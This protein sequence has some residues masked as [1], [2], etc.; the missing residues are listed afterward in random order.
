MGDLILGF[1]LFVLAVVA[2]EE[3]SQRRND[4]YKTGYGIKKP[5]RLD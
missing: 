5:N 1:V 2:Q 3:Y 4:G